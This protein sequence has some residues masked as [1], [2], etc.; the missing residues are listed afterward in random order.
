MGPFCKLCGFNFKLLQP[1]STKM[2]GEP[3]P[4]VNGVLTPP[5]RSSASSTRTVG[6]PQVTVRLKAVVSCDRQLYDDLHYQDRQELAFP[7]HEPAIA[8]PLTGAEM[9]IGRASRQSSTHPHICI[10]A[11]PG[12]SRQHA[13]LLRQEDGSYAILDVGSAGGTLLNGQPIQGKLT[14]L[15]AGDVLVIGAWTRIDILTQ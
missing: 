5:A 10:S 9:L 11:D 14:P 15:R 6:G 4:H 1:A 12:V 7:E 13:R 3:M 2:P 8:F